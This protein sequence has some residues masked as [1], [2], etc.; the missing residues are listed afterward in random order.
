MAIR[1]KACGSC[2]WL[3]L[4]HYPRTH[5]QTRILCCLGIGC[6]QDRFRVLLESRFPTSKLHGLAKLDYWQLP[7][8]QTPSIS[9]SE[10]T[11][12]Q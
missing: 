8:T 1:I 12:A 6:P 7:H 9:R 2:S 3:V 10:L 4:R 5:A 11:P